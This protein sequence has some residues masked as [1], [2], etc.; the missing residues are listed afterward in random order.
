MRSSESRL[1][2]T[3]AFSVLISKCG[4]LLISDEEWRENDSSPEASPTSLLGSEI[5]KQPALQW[6]PRNLQLVHKAVPGLGK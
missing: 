4:G 5:R 3:E 6:R 2:N 1:G